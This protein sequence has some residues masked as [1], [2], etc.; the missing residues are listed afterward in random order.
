MITNK[1]Y[2]YYVLGKRLI[3]KVSF[4][5]ILLLIPAFT[6]LITFSARQDSGLVRIALASEGR[7]AFS[8]ALTDR[9]DA[10]S[11]VVQY[12]RC[13]SPDEAV[14]LVQRGG[15]DAAWVL[16]KDI[17][18]EIKKVYEGKNAKLVRIY[19][20]EDNVLVRAS[21]ERLFACIYP[22][23][24]YGV[25]ERAAL[26]IDAQSAESTYN[27]FGDFGDVIEFEFK[28]NEADFEN[29]SYITS[30]LRGILASVML[31]C[32]LAATFYFRTDDKNGVFST[33]G[34]REKLFVSFA[35]NLAA[36]SVSAVFVTVALV[37]SGIYT[38]FIRETVLM[39]L[40]VLA[41]AL[42][43]TL[44][45]ALFKSPTKM[46]VM[47]PTVL[48]LSLAMTP[49]FFNIKSFKAVSLLLPP[50]YYLYGTGDMSF[51]VGLALYTL[52]A[53][54]ILWLKNRQ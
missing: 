30:P 6:L 47:L 11:K 23:I 2:L 50:Y 5:I 36:L 29:A 10:Q 39:V 52:I 3:K 49:V 20:V 28:S 46:A 16:K 31:L 17:G 41:S 24:A 26:P 8:V 37:L 53:G 9:I 19:A 35:N 44:L 12:I 38:A 51:A 25:Y 18:E 48:I 14:A 15:A 42:F 1:F 4:L 13:D 32:G 45:G 40:F 21:R 43:C 7:D 34:E 27:M 54:A 33:L 22:E